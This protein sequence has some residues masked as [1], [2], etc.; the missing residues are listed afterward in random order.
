MFHLGTWARNRK[1]DGGSAAVSFALLFPVFFFLLTSLLEFGLFLFVGANLEA[2]VRDAS[3]F[4]TTGAEV[5]GMSREERIL[6]IVEERTLGKLRPDD[7]QVS[8]QV[9]PSFAAI[10]SE[11]GTAGAGGPGDVVLYEVRYS[12]SAITPIM[13]P[14]LDGRILSAAVAIRNEDF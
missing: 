11:T 13:A 14:L 12:W 8:T 2:G 1:D 6:A 5:S 10:S 4:G 9:F 3:R 7:A